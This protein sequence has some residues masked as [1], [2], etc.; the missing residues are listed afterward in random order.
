MFEPMLAFMVV[1]ELFVF[2]LAA[3]LSIIKPPEHR[4]SD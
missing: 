4:H 2:W 3:A 1:V